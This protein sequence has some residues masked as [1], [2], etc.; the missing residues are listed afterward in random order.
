TGELVAERRS[1]VERGGGGRVDGACFRVIHPVLEVLLWFARANACRWCSFHAFVQC[2][3][4]SPSHCLTLHWLRSHVGRSGVGPQ[5]GRA[6]VVV[7]F[8]A[9]GSAC[10]P[11]TLWRSEVA[12]PG[13]ETSFSHGCLVSLGLTPSCSFPTLWRSGML[14]LVSW[15]F[16]FTRLL[17]CSV[18]SFVSAVPAALASKGLA[19]PTE[20]VCEA[21]PP[22]SLQVASFPAGSEC[23][24]AAA[25]YAC[26]EHG[27]WFARAVFG[28][29]VVLRIRVG[30]SQRLREPT[31]GVAFTGA[32]LWSA[33]PVE[34][35][36]ALLTL[37]VNSG[38]VFSE[39]FS[40][41]FWWNGG[42]LSLWDYFFEVHRLLS[43]CSGDG[44]PERFAVVLNGAFVVLV[45]VLPEPVCVASA[46]YCIISVG[47]LFGLRS[48]VIVAGWTVLV[49]VFLGVV[50]QG[51][52]PLTVGLAV[53]LT[54]H[55]SVCVL[56]VPQLCLEVLVAVG[57]VAL[58][59][60]GGGGGA[61]V[62]SVGLESF[63]AV[64][65]V[66]YCTLSVFSFSMLRVS[67]REFF[68]LAYVVSAVG[69][70][71]LHPAEFWCLWWHPLLVLEWFVFVPSGALVHS[72]VPWVAPGAGVSTVCSACSPIGGVLAF[73]GST[74]V[75]CP[76]RTMRMIWVG[77]SGAGAHCPA[78]RGV[79]HVHAIAWFWV[80]IKKLSFRL[81]V[82]IECQARHSVCGEVMV[83]TT[84]KLWHLFLLFSFPPSSLLLSEVGRLPLSSSGG[85][86]MVESSASSWRSGGAS[87]SEEEAAEVFVKA[88]LGLVLRS[89]LLMLNATGRYVAFISEGGTLVV[90]TWWRQALV[91]CGPA[92]PSHC[93]ALRWLRSHIGRSGVGPQLD[94]AAVVVLF[95][96]VTH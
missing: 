2:G 27:C 51:V 40:A 69:A 39:F 37:V 88:H 62:P 33:E 23:V 81:S 65:A 4:A 67:C 29:V 61:L 43:L 72:V 94:R 57:R 8:L 90:A 54:R 36:L 74:V 85:L 26:F 75:V 59:T 3:L 17:R 66:A 15:D 22:Y 70:T 14:V 35:V 50:D 60:C 49:A 11:S 77:S 83:L 41:G 42:F 71:M 73:C 48:A 20:L 10:G 31:C 30:V 16:G 84:G 46:V 21:H 86:G 24:A 53:V 13:G 28:F 93:L 5:L 32:R 87:W 79:L 92:S 47:R 64:G 9:G 52:V 12:V 44:F 78:C 45:K 55:C 1:I 56:L 7:L 63:Q 91:R 58:P 95:L 25:G 6:A 96:A 18:S 89:H 82:A 68:L 80:T 19:I 34:G 76:G 38:E